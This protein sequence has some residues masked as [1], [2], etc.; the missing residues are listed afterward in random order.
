MEDSR[1][2]TT[3]IAEALA[4]GTTELLGSQLGVREE[5]SIVAVLKEPGE[6]NSRSE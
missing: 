4:S 2:G 1:C 5:N 3:S 6:G